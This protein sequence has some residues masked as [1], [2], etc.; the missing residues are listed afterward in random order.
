MKLFDP[1]TGFLLGDP[2][3]CPFPAGWRPEP[4]EI[5][6][7]LSPLILSASGWRKI[8]AGDGSEESGTPELSLP[9]RVLAGLMAVA[10][11]SFLKEKSGLPEPRVLVG[12]DSRP[13]GPALADVMIRV[14]LA[15]NL[16][17]VYT[18]IT[19]APEL[20]ARAGEDPEIQGF[21]YISASHNPLGHNGLK[22]GLN[23][24]G[25][26]GGDGAAQLIARFR[27][28][29]GD[30]EAPAAMI[31]LVQ[32]LPAEAVEAV[33]RKAGEAKEETAG[34]YTR[35]SRRVVSG[36][37]D[38]ARQEELLN[39]LSRRC[40]ERGAGILGELNGSA[41]SLSI[42]RPFLEASGVICRSL[43]D[44][45]RQ[46]VHR[47]VPE[48]P[49]LDLCRQELDRARREDPRF[50]LGYVPDNDGDRG[51]LV[52]WN[53]RSGRSEI[54][55]AQEVFALSVLAELAWLEY[56]A[57]RFPGEPELSAPRGVAV[58]GPTSLR[59]EAIARAFGARVFRAEV[60]EANVV[61][62]AR[63]AREEGFAVPI[64]GEGSNGGNIT[65]PAAVRDPLNTLFALLKLLH[66]T[67]EGDVPGLFES[68][69]LRSGRPE[70]YRPD[71]T[72]TDILL[73]L[74]AFTTTSAFEDRALLQ[75]RT[76]DHGLLKARYE[77]AFPGQ[78]ENRKKRLRDRWGIC[79]W[80]EINYEG[81]R[82]VTGTGPACR[83]GAQRG[84]LKIQFLDGTGEPAGFIW[85][86]GSGTEPVFRIM[87]DLRGTDR[88]GEAE[89]LDWQREMILAADSRG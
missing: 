71:F 31:A 56:L 12:L 60:G 64:L 17:V 54:L 66:I 86:R 88:E 41:R 14:F 58:N 51:N 18:F 50:V 33:Y 46:V 81:T 49:S 85:M 4:E 45:P 40:R 3:T 62:R 63:E 78:W 20:M 16:K 38:P 65:F 76:E 29:A 73:S 82:A 70:L 26:V 10:F 15:L 35:F 19:A 68:W 34:Y 36:M 2:E 89:I 55:E 42:D 47:I 37:K 7:A 84:G 13:T 21:A 44:R 69:C 87:A 25:V 53:D 28:L 83:T 72:L 67:R 52:Y 48:G 39:L 32:G 27:A 22:F 8:F 75:I 80:E 59:I 24:G 74:P 11:A 77:E 1:K 30:P 9:D 79:S 43:N 61:N 23:D 5:R 57:A 6:Y